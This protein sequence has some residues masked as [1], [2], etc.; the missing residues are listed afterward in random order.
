MTEFVLK[1]RMPGQKE[2][3]YHFPEHRCAWP[4]LPKKDEHIWLTIGKSREFHLR[5]RVRAR[6]AEADHFM[7]DPLP[8][9]IE[10]TVE[11]V[12]EVYEAMFGDPTW[13]RCFPA[14]S[15]VIGLNQSQRPGS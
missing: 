7:D 6:V 5:E 12:E 1:V 8:P 2:G 13:Q 10:V 3:A 11:V 15:S 14:K 9:L 4:E